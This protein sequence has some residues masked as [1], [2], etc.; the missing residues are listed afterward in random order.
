MTTHSR[1]CSCNPGLLPHS[2]TITKGSDGDKV[3]IWQ[4]E[5]CGAVVVEPHID[6][7]AVIDAELE[8]LLTTLGR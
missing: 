6:L 1:A 2:V 4:C 8:R 7:E 3:E 5:C